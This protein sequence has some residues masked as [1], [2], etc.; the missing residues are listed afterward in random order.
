MFTMKC[1]KIQIFSALFFNMTLGFAGV[2]SAVNIYECTN[3]QEQHKIFQDKPCAK[4]FNEK[5]HEY[6]VSDS[7]PSDTLRNYEIVMLD[8]FHEMD[9]ERLRYRLE[10]ENQYRLAQ[11]RFE[12]LEAYEKIRHQQAIEMFDKHYRHFWAYGYNNGGG[13]IFNPYEFGVALT[14]APILPPAAP[15]S[16]PPAIPSPKPTV[17]G[18]S[19]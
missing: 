15:I 2:V 19:P 1:S 14:P 4:G 13:E 5:T 7:A 9:K 6:L 12:H 17:P 16:T 18:T 10:L 3:D 11:Q 8:R